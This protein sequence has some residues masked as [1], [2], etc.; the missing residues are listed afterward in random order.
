MTRRSWSDLSDRSKTAILA[1]PASRRPGSTSPGPA[2]ARQQPI[3]DA[4]P[5]ARLVRLGQRRRRTRSRELQREGPDLRPARLLRCW[6]ERRTCPTGR[7]QTTPRVRDRSATRWRLPCTRRLSSRCGVDVAAAE[8]DQ[9]VAAWLPFDS[10]RA[11]DGH[12]G[13][14]DVARQGCVESVLA[15]CPPSVGGTRGGRGPQRPRPPG[16]RRRAAPATGL[17]RRRR[18]Y[19]RKLNPSRCRVRLCC[20]PLACWGGR[21]TGFVTDRPHPQGDVVGVLVALGH[22]AFCLRRAC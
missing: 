14:N 11:A 9:A 5:A 13:R 4:T 17:A 2:S 19:R 1:R 18:P 8:R 12:G 22:G 16:P 20:L 21:V 15:L 7:I 6:P 3:D 10:V